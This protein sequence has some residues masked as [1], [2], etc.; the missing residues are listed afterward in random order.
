LRCA[1]QPMGQDAAE[2]A[3]PNQRRSSCFA[4]SVSLSSRP[5]LSALPLSLQPRHRPGDGAAGSAASTAGF[6]RDGA[7]G[8]SATATAAARDGA[9]SI[10]IAASVPSDPG[11]TGLMRGSQGG[12]AF[13]LRRTGAV[14]TVHAAD[15]GAQ[16]RLLAHYCR[17]RATTCLQP[18]KADA[19]ST[20]HPLINRPNVASATQKG[21][22][23][24]TGCR[25]EASD[26][27]KGGS[28]RRPGLRRRR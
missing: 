12:A 8:V 19:A 27:I 14:E 24:D 25:A 4:R 20:T 16:R 1:L 23:S 5:P 3:S 10:R 7:I 22:E 6:M 2:R 26:I 11:N 17:A 15:P 28:E 21:K 18:A 13:S 9:I